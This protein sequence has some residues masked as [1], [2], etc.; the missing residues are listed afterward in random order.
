ME[1]GIGVSYLL[2]GFEGSDHIQLVDASSHDGG[3]EGR[4]SKDSEGNKSNCVTVD[5]KGNAIHFGGKGLGDESTEKISN[6]KTNRDCQQR[7]DGK[8]SE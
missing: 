7:E 8:F 6:S 3:R 4:G 1:V 2:T 5:D